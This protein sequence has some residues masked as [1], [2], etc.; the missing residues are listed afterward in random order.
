MTVR[1]RNLENRFNHRQPATPTETELHE[2]LSKKFVEFSAYLNEVLDEGRAKSLMLTELENASS[3]A[4]KALDDTIERLETPAPAPTPEAA[5]KKF[6]YRKP[7][8]TKP[9]NNKFNHRKP[10]PNDPNKKEK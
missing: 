4:H 9:G 10:G 8:L 7:N 1:L 6:N 5:A 3:W 2:S